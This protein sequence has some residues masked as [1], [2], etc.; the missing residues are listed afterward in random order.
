MSLLRIRAPLGAAPTR[1]EWA[2]LDARQSVPGEGT[3]AQLPRRAQRVQLLVPAAQ[4]LITRATLPK[5]AQRRAG[6]VL[7]FAVEEASAAEPEANQVSW[8][9]ALDGQAAGVGALA[10]LDKAGLER[11]RDALQAVGLRQF[12]PRRPPRHG[13]LHASLADQ[14]G[15][16]YFVQMNTEPT[17]G[18]K[19]LVGF[20]GAGGEVPGVGVGVVAA[21]RH[22]CALRDLNPQPSDPKSDALS[23]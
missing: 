12:E 8:L 10:V 21:N 14:R 23:N 15:T 20:H 5:G 2:L 17:A 1:C 16:F 13:P 3:L 19:G 11:W 22:E 6:P 9:G 18:S 7:A 4:A